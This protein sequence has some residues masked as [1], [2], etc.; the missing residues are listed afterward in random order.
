MDFLSVKQNKIVDLSGNEII[1]KGINLG[2]WLMMEGY[3]LGGRNIPEYKFKEKFEQKNCADSLEEFEKLFRD[4]FIK[5]EDLVNIS[6]LGFNCVRVPVHYSIVEKD[7]L[8]YIDSLLD[9][10][11]LTGLYCILDLHAVPGSQNGQWHSDGKDED[12][13]FWGNRKFIERYLKIWDCLSCRYKDREE[14]AAYNIMNEP[15]VREDAEV[16]IASV[17]EEVT[18][19]IRKND[20]RHMIMAEGNFWSTDLE[21]LGAPEDENTFYSFHLYDPMNFTY[22]LNRDLK[23]PG[24]IDGEIWDKNKLRK[25]LKY[26]KDVQER[27]DVPLLAGEFG[28]NASCGCR[29]EY[30]WV[31]DV[32]DLFDE[33]SFH[34]TYWTYKSVPIYVFPDGLYKYNF[35]PPW[36][37]RE[38]SCSGWEKW[39]QIWKKEKENI[40]K[41]LDTCE[42]RVDEKLK[43]ALTERL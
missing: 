4:N 30:K 6:R 18:R 38:S 23:Y 31:E 17:Y 22:N 16:R 21:V 3:I 5:W 1:L 27:W 19:V 29:G 9:W 14:L 36:V 25:R 11:S 43:Q 34:W 7:N 32:L 20:E 39:I 35:N 26:F 37:S 42:F 12:P 8:G 15:V 40:V 28:V 10:C 33:F 24:E 2:G 13:R 41:S